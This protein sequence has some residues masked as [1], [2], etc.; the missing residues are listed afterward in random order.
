M[1]NE[2]T[3][4]CDQ[5]GLT[6]GGQP[7]SLN[8]ALRRIYYDWDKV[9]LQNFMNSLLAAETSGIGDALFDD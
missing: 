4:I 9:Q 6:N 3:K 1:T 7:I 5:F 8:E 2:L